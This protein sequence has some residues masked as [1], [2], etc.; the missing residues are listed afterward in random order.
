MKGLLCENLPFLFLRYWLS[1][2]LHRAPSFI[3]FCVTVC[4]VLHVYF[5]SLF[6]D[7][8]HYIMKLNFFIILF[9]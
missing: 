5:S 4:V 3:S 2:F 1:L 9:I 7:S 8:L 6:F